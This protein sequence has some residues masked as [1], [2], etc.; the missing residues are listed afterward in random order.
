MRTKII[1]EHKRSKSWLK[2]ERDM[3]LLATPSGPRFL[4]VFSGLCV[5]LPLQARIETIGL[6]VSWIRSCWRVLRDTYI[7]MH[8]AF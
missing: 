1:Y 5:L 4:V 2:Y 8:Y 6:G 3:Q 7:G